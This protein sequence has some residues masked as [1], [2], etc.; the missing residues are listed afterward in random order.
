MFNKRFRQSFCS[1]D[2][3]EKYGRPEQATGDDMAHAHY[4]LGI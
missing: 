4:M 2:N 1:W 3:V